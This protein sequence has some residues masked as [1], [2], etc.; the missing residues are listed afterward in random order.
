[1]DDSIFKT[2]HP[3]VRAARGPGL[4]SATTFEVLMTPVGL[5]D[6]NETHQEATT[7]L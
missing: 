5:S 4:Q 3:S 6:L 7:L 2:H 1:M